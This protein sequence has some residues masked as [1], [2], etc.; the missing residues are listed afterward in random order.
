MNFTD[1]QI[2]FYAGGNNLLK[3]V[4]GATN[5]YIDLA[6]AS[7]SY[8][9]VGGSNSSIKFYVYSL[10]ANNKTY[11][12]YTY[13]QRNNTNLDVYGTY[14]RADASG[15]YYPNVYG[16]YNYGYNSATSTA[17]T[18]WTY[19]SWNQSYITSTNGLSRS[20][21]LYSAHIGTSADLSYAGFFSGRVYSTVGYTTSDQKLKKNINT[22]NSS[23][24]KIM[25][26]PVKTYDFRTTEYAHMNLPDGNHVGIMAQDLE[27]TYPE[28]VSQAAQPPLDS[29]TQ[30]M[31]VEAGQV[32]PEKAKDEVVFKAVNYTGLVPPFSKSYAR[33]TS[34]Y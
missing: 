29:A 23:L 16:S 19:G 10:A 12:S 9:G 1:D 18:K 24:D 4:E 17:S 30:A 14:N 34:Y 32:V 28:L 7:G 20:Y 22:L 5:D 33:T 31:M 25:L 8:V 11:G 26:L 15:A 21:G 13:N 2:N 27:K 3:M 6:T